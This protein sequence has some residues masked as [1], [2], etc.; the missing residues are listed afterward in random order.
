[1]GCL[2]NLLERSLFSVEWLKRYINTK[3]QIRKR[4]S[5]NFYRADV[6]VGGY[7]HFENKINV[8]MCIYLFAIDHKNVIVYIQVCYK[9][10]W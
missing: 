3:I 10:Y 4:S 9:P 5:W 1:M 2:L 8:C 6:T 7:A